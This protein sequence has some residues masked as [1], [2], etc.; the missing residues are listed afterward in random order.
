[1]H[2]KVLRGLLTLNNNKKD[3]LLHILSANRKEIF[4]TRFKT[5]RTDLQVEFGAEVLHNGLTGELFG[6]VLDL[7]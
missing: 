4:Q 5:N 6:T 3:F 7:H 2:T 1:M